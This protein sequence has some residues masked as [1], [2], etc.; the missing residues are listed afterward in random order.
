[1]DNATPLVFLWTVYGRFAYALLL[2]SR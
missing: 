1:V 2:A